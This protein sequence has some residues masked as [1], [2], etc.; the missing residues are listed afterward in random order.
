MFLLS[1]LK[2]QII[3]RVCEKKKEKKRKEERKSESLVMWFMI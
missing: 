1:H 3:G 2:F